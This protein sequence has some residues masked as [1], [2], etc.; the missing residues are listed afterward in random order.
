MSHEPP[1]QQMAGLK[2]G[3][4][5]Q[6]AKEFTGPPTDGVSSV[7]PIAVKPGGIVFRYDVEINRI[8]LN[9]SLTKAGA[10]DGQKSLLRKLC[11][12]LMRNV[13]NRTE[14]FRSRAPGVEST[15]YVYDSRKNLFTNKEINLEPGPIEIRPEEMDEFC[16]LSLRNSP[17]TVEIT[18]SL[19]FELRLDDVKPGLCTDATLTA[20]HSLR[21]FLELATSQPFLNAGTH[22]VIGIG[23]VFEK[24]ASSDLKQGLSTHRGIAKGVRIIENNGKPAPALVI[25]VKTCA[26]YKEQTLDRSV[27]EMMQ[28]SRNAKPDANLFNKVRSLFKGVRGTLVYAPSRSIV[29][30]GFTSH[31]VKDILLKMKDTGEEITMVQFFQRRYQVTIPVEQQSWPAVRSEASRDAVFPLSL[32]QIMPNQRVPLEKMSENISSALLTLNSTHPNERY[33]AILREVR[34]IA[35]GHSG[36]FLMSFGVKIPPGGNSVQMNTRTAPKIEFGDK[37][38]VMS[39]GGRFDERGWRVFRPGRQ[40][41][42]WLIAHSSNDQVQDNVKNWASQIIRAAG[43][44]GLRLPQPEYRVMDLKDIIQSF[45]SI[46]KAGYEYVFYIDSKREKSHDNLKLMEARYKSI[47]TQQLTVE[48]LQKAGGATYSNIVAKMNM[49]LAGQNYIPKVENVAGKFE[50]NSG[51][52]LV[53]GYNVSHPPKATAHELYKMKDIKIEGEKIDYASLEPSVVGICGNY[54]SEPHSFVGDFFYQPARKEMVDEAMLEQKMSWIL[55]KFAENRRGAPLPPLVFVVRDGVSEGQ[56]PMTISKELPALKAGCRRHNP[57]Y[58]PKFIV[59]IVNKKHQKRFF[60]KEQGERHGNTLPGTVIDRK[61]VRPDVPEFYLQSHR[62]LKGTAKIPQYAVPVNEINASTDEL[63]G[64]L[65]ALCHSHQIV[66][67]AISV[68][69]PVYQAT[70][71]AKRGAANYRTLS[72]QFPAMIPRQDQLIDYAALSLR[73]GY[74]KSKLNNAR[75]TA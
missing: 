20:D 58:N 55:A 57:A 73:L 21:T 71:L 14:D 32:V 68:P 15:L 24:R 54:A 65:N 51:K 53:I 43:Q 50:L 13:Y 8:D 41:S 56:F 31:A 70:E 46:A 67:S 64:F 2:L 72:S 27:K 38:T 35:S 4:C 5:V 66:N 25:D 37:K 26:F 17:V 3:H 74:E 7:F 1:L 36:N 44:K 12:T 11:A 18:K 52:I 48:T 39:V 19:A 61:V 47:P 59:V 40:I 6:P 34:Q 49:K 42:K 33:Q 28:D 16:R 69:A 9:K 75:F 62:P 10:D 29:I 60:L 63:Q 23:K 22:E 30:D 45:E